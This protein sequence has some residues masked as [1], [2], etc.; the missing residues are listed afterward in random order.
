[1]E[2]CDV[3]SSLLINYLSNYSAVRL[4]CKG[5]ENVYISENFANETLLCQTSLMICNTS[6]FLCFPAD[7]NIIYSLL[8][9]KGDERTC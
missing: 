7:S 3:R 9:R 5:L 1:M 2:L 6:S 4:K 8:S